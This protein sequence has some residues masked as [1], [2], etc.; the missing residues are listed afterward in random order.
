[1][2]YNQYF[3][4]NSMDLDLS[5]TILWNILYI[6]NYKKAS[7]STVKGPLLGLIL[8]IAQNHTT[9]GSIPSQHDCFKDCLCA[10]E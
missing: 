6:L 8:T 10:R 4:D 1:M 9:P 7:M 2:S 3:P 5:R